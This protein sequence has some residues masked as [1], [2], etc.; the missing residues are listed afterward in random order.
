MIQS[1]G[2]AA[3]LARLRVEVETDHEALVARSREL[4][5]LL[6]RWPSDAMPSDERDVIVAAVTVHA[7]YTALE[8]LLERVA[9]L[10]DESV[11]TGAAWHAD[12]CSQMAVDVPGL[13]DAVLDRRL[14]P[15]LGEVRKFRHFFRNAYVLSFDPG[16]V[17][18]QAARVCALSPSIQA[19]VD[20]LLSQVKALQEE[21]QQVDDEDT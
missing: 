10:L 2:V 9:R 17:R 16:R 13:R 1:A 20:R 14:L 19:G 21:L 8:A 4:D 6:Q 7:W 5:L 12:L 11:P 3:R 18:E 15:D